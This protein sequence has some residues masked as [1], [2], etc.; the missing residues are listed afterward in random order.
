[1]RRSIPCGFSHT[2]T[3]T[4]AHTQRIEYPCGVH[5][6][7]R[8]CGVHRT[9]WQRVRLYCLVGAHANGADTHSV[10][11]AYVGARWPARS[12][13]MTPLAFGRR[14]IPS[15]LLYMCT[16]VLCILSDVWR[17]AHTCGFQTNAQQ[18]P[19]PSNTQPPLLYGLCIR[20]PDCLCRTAEPYKL[21]H[22]ADW[23][24]T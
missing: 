8:F 22:Y 24:P 16:K 12:R 18:R 4:H 5:A 17:F 10:P 6:R 13:T 1:M 9:V 21:K 15:C 7:I 20:L 11:W 14:Y 23:T 19:G 2:Q 3:Q